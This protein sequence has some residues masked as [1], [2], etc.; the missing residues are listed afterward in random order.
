MGIW[1]ENFSDRHGALL[2]NTQ[3]V[4]P[5]L[6]SIILI[7]KF[8]FQLGAPVEVLAR[9]A[10]NLQIVKPTSIG[11]NYLPHISLAVFY[12]FLL[13]L[14]TNI[15]INGIVPGDDRRYVFHF[16]PRNGFTI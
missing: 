10:A 12:L 6:I 13:Q 14:S 5:S 16:N 4:M 8:S 1:V 15:K 11:N 3:T 2:L 7:R 9:A